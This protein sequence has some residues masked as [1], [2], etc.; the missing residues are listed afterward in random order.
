MTGLIYGS[1]TVLI[2]CC[3]ASAVWVG[4]KVVDLTVNRSDAWGDWSLPLAIVVTWVWLV[5][6]ILAT[7]FNYV[8]LFPQL[9]Y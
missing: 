5:A 8:T 9:F 6:A 3:F 4:V 7:V 1:F 2:L